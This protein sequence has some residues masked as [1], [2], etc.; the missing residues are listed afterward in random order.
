MLFLRT[1]KA[2]IQLEE[3]QSIHMM[4]LLK[5]EQKDAV[6]GNFLAHRKRKALLVN[7]IWSLGERQR[8]EPEIR[9]WCSNFPL[10]GKAQRR[11]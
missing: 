9:P 3:D 5:W 6:Q 1:P 2:D 4:E 8:E 11:N 7:R 10:Q